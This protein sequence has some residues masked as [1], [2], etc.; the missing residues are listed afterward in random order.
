MRPY[1]DF[2]RSVPLDPRNDDL[3]TPYSSDRVGH[4]SRVAFFGRS[5]CAEDCQR[6]GGGILSL[7]PAFMPELAHGFMA[8]I[9]LRL[10]PKKV[11]MFARLS[12][13]EDPFPPGGG[14]EPLT[15]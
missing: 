8:L 4:G 13:T 12:G 15:V 7:S 14:P 10:T 3:T 1:C 6:V 9:S 5:S 11:A 2:P